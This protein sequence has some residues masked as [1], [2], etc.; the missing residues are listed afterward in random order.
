VF[1]L[2][3]IFVLLFCLVSQVMAQ[4]HPYSI[5]GKAESKSEEYEK[6]SWYYDKNR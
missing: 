4:V 3:D 6:P 5:K 1:K 2:K